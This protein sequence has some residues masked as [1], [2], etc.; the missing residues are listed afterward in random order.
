MLEMRSFIEVILF[1]IKRME[2]PT[3]DEISHALIRQ[4]GL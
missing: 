3:H 4:L 2:S 1:S